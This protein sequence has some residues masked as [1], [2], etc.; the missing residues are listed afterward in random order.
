M[1][2]GCRSGLAPNARAQRRRW[3]V[4]NDLNTRAIKEAVVWSMPH[5]EI[6]RVA[7]F[8]ADADVKRN[9]RKRCR[10]VVPEET[11]DVSCKHRLRVLKNSDVGGRSASQIDPLKT[12]L[13]E[14]LA[15]DWGCKPQNRISSV[16]TR[17]KIQ[18]IGRVDD[19]T[20]DHLASTVVDD[21]WSAIRGTPQF[22]L[23]SLNTRR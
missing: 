15:S 14:V 17:I 16:I 23:R 2:S 18:D 7:R 8:G 5:G 20:L 19:S 9:D 3:T 13:H 12:A 21:V 1:C 10:D 4:N 6:D 22:K 11:T